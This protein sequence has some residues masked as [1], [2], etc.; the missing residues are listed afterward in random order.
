MV[1]ELSEQGTKERTTIFAGGTELASQTITGGNQS[2]QWH[3]YDS[4]NASYRATDATGQGHWNAAKEL[5][6]LGGNAGLVKP[7]TWNVPDRRGLPVP[8]PEF[9]D[10]LTNPGGGCAARGMPSSCHG[11]GQDGRG[12]PDFAFW[13][14]RIADLPGF[15]TNWGSLGE[16]AYREHGVRVVTS[17]YRSLHDRREGNLR[18]SDEESL[19]ALARSFAQEPVTIPVGNL[20]GNLEALLKT[21]DCRNFTNRVLAELAKKYSN[22]DNRQHIKT[23]LEGFN[24]VSAQGGFLLESKSFHTVRGDLFNNARNNNAGPGTVLILPNGQ[25]RA[26]TAAETALFQAL[27]AWTALHETFHLGKRGGYSDEQV[28]RVMAELDGTELPTRT[29]DGTL[30]SSLTTYDWKRVTAFSSSLDR[31]LQRHCAYPTTTV[32]PPGIDR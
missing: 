17:L 5:D 31:A 21:G 32:L 7:F 10:M 25:Y 20:R 22:P 6:P 8:F 23:V 14:S 9:A 24:M 26:P 18:P 2:V 30:I 13:G 15:G 4:S 11:A 27:Y 1:T 12:G 16:L 28:A 3:H 29:Q 19:C